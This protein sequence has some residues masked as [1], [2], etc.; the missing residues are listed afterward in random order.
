M[1]HEH[2]DIE[3][4]LQLLGSRTESARSTLT[5]LRKVLEQHNFK[6]EAVLYPMLDDALAE[7]RGEL[8]ETVFREIG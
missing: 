8:V 2:R 1:E 3:R 4:R 5:E 6:E 7:R